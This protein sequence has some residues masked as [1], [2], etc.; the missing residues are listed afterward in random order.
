M[1]EI[2]T[3]LS[4]DDI[5]VKKIVICGGGPGG[6]LA[7]LC[8]LGRNT[9]AAAAAGQKYHVTLIDDRQ[10]YGT[11]S[12]ED[13]SEH[14]SWMIV[15]SNQ[16][17]DAIRSI[18]GLWNEY[19][20]GIGVRV[21]R[22]AI[23]LGSREIKVENEEGTE[24]YVV[25]RNYI[26]WALTKSLMDRYGDQ[27]E[28]FTALY[29]TK[30]MFVD[31]AKKQ[32][33]VRNMEGVAQTEKYLDYDILIGADGIRSVVRSAML[34]HEKHMECSVSDIFFRFKSVH[35]KRPE[36]FQSTSMHLLPDIVP[37]MTGIG[38]PEPGNYFNLNM[39]YQRHAPCEAGLNS[40]DPKIVA[41]YLRTSWKAAGK[42]DFDDMAEQ[43]ANQ[44]WNST[45][46]VHCNMYHSEDVGALI[47]GDAAHATSP[48]I[49][50]GMNTALADAAILNRILDD[51]KD[52]WTRALPM[53]SEE[54]VK[55][56]YA[57]TTMSYYRFSMKPSQS[58]KYLIIGGIRELLH[59]AGFTFIQRDPQAMVALGYKLSEC[60]NA[61]CQ[62]GVIPAIRTTNDKIRREWEE[63]QMGLVSS[64]LTNKKS[65]Y[66]LIALGAVA[67]LTAV[68]VGRTRK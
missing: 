61:A 2:N 34:Q 25:D 60:Y 55:E 33:Y 43:W 45:G 4:D 1:S 19:V 11:I 36:E 37:H 31:G 13:L 38:L 27:K 22:T 51:Y 18:P 15:L 3:L 32:I 47:L 53:Y 67:A 28:S 6:I 58:L 54:R 42:V 12:R 50:M 14:R 23:H 44:R 65:R 26:V 66:M 57:L 59:K 39:G 30:C 20:E 35:V 5:P 68:V 63:D 10:N 62:Q 16:G 9:S 7:A 17:M 52:D 48:A 56:G 24:T 49:G 29:N 40:D 46:Q 8:L 64:K 41:E 21:D